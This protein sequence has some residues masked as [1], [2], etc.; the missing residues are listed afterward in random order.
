MTLVLGHFLWAGLLLGAFV[1]FPIWSL[2]RRAQTPAVLLVE[3]G[4]LQRLVSW[5]LMA[6]LFTAIP[7]LPFLVHSGVARRFSYLLIPRAGVS[8]TSSTLR[9]RS[10][11]PEHSLAAIILVFLQK[12][13]REI[14]P[15]PSVSSMRFGAARQGPRIIPFDGAYWY[16]KAPDLRPPPGT[17]TLHR[18]PTKA[19]IRSTDSQPLIME[20]HQNLGSAV[21]LGSYHAVRLAIRNADNRPGLIAIEL[22]FTNTNSNTPEVQSLGTLP[23]RSSQE[24]PIAWN[25]PP[26]DEVLNFQVSHVARGKSFN[27]ITVLIKASEQRARS[28]AQ[29]AVQHFELE[30]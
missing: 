9:P 26:T 17:Q 5:S 30:P 23:V 19:N 12:P 1:I 16:F 28:G 4:R 24:G 18:D 6:V 11:A 10:L 2:R 14:A 29:I 13:K 22:L 8:P 7:L 15:P 27:Q 21:N 25:R 20:A 3:R